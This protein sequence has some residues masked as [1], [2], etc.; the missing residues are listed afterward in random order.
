M[1]SFE[2]QAGDDAMPSVKVS[3]RTVLATTGVAA[4]AIGLAAAGLGRIAGAQEATPAGDLPAVPPELETY[5]N[6]WPVAG[7]DLAATR[8]ARGSKIDSSNVDQLGVAWEI[9]SQASSGFG[10]ISSNPIIL[11]DTTYLIDNSASIWAVDLAS[12]EV[13]WRKEYNVPTWGPNGLALGYGILIGV[14]GDTAETVAL[15]PETGDELWRFQ[16][17][18]HNALG[19]TMA[20]LIYDGMVIVST[21]PGGNTKGTYEGGANGVVYALDVQTGIT[22]WTWDTIDDDMWGNFVVNN[23][24]GLWYPPSVDENG[25]F[26]MGIGN[27]GPWPGTEEFPA[28][29]S[30]PGENNYANNLVAL[31][32]K[33]GKVLWNIN[34]KPHDL[35]DL[36]NQ[37]TPLVANVE[38]G[39][40]DTGVVF[41]SG[42]HGYV[43]CAARESGTE[44][45]RRSVGYHQNDTTLT[46]NDTEPLE[47][48][49]GALGGVES[50]LAFADGVLY[51]VAW[52]YPTSYTKTAINAGTFDYT[53]ATTDL[54]AIEGA[55]GE[56]IWHTQV[57][58]GIAGP[59]PVI[60][61]DIFF[62]GSLDGI[63]R[64]FTIADG[65]Q[66]W[67]SQTSAGINA[68]FALAGDTL[69]VP[70]GSFIAPSADSPETLPG[71]Q[72]TFIAYRL[73]ATG[74]PTLAEPSASVDTSTV[75]NSATNLTIE[76]Y[77]LGYRPNT[78]TI[79]ADTD[80][81]IT[82]INTG[83]LQH[84]LQV[85]DP[86]V[87]SGMVDGG[88]ETTFTVNL[89][90]GTY[91][92]FCSVEGH[93]A[94]G[95]VGTFTVE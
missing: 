93:A 58:Y 27:A 4:G 88:S 70:A 34:I 16:L 48:Y 10:A 66:V 84:D 74:T 95:M 25:I 90:A 1:S 83:V 12:G 57:P 92:W 43:V 31:D 13:K 8:V 50:Q 45:W 63:V 85:T 72:P 55:T 94:S 17:A 3:R 51:V 22:L 35:F 78:A 26:Y 75:E 77:D 38:I 80:V 79:A 59:G 61:N 11:G 28:G 37:L 82:L 14:L 52:N 21:E 60:S 62:T 33:Q 46:L 47:V 89:P 2:D 6:D 76:A 5:A 40:V 69:I 64:A 32:P 68:S 49:P 67:T 39:G 73:G 18:N 15:D 36:D 19:I 65:T 56:I 86:A 20:P 42:K 54:Y 44:I 7:A 23:G 24:G 29:S 71:V 81:T 9:Q 91:Q 53:S 87:D 41:S 30:R